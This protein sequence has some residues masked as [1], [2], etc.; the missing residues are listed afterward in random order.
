MRGTLF[1]SSHCGASRRGHDLL[2]GIAVAEMVEG[3]KDEAVLLRIERA[4]LSGAVRLGFVF[5]S[6][7]S[8]KFEGGSIE[9][10][11]RCARPTLV[12]ALNWHLFIRV[13]KPCGSVRIG[14]AHCLGAESVSQRHIQ[15]QPER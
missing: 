8:G 9:N 15:E 2:I 14:I 6:A 12:Q 7:E 11:G 5:G 1:V 3:P 13:D 4:A 10:V